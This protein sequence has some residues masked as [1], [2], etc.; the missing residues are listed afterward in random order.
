MY[1]IISRHQGLL[2]WLASKGITG[3]VIPHATSDD[4]RGKNVIGNL[5]LHLAA[6]ADTVTVVNLP[7]LPAELRG[8]EL[9]A[10][11]MD[12]YG[13]SLATYK[14]KHLSHI[15]ITRSRTVKIR[16]KTSMTA[17]FRRLEFVEPQVEIKHRHDGTFNIY[18]IYADDG[19]LLGE[20]FKWSQRE[21][22][23]PALGVKVEWVSD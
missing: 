11:E 23:K 14:V 6:L 3:R 19:Q 8:K 5:P 17:G 21:E 10:E 16:V 12:Q 7:N 22:F 2:D 1:V 4:V 20:T 15:D 9:S 13:A 18:E